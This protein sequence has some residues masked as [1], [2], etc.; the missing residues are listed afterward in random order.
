MRHH[1]RFRSPILSRPLRVCNTLPLRNRN[2]ACP[3]AP[4]TNQKWPQPR[5]RAAVDTTVIG[6]L[7]CPGG[8]M[9]EVG[10]L[11]R[12]WRERGGL[13]QTALARR[14][15]VNPAYV[16][17]LEHGGRGAHNRDLLESAADALGLS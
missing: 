12:G 17:R 14:M 9:D 6:G 10:P 7:Q 11:L 13:S 3:M 16:N 5:C 1:H 2:G 4:I 8:A 15:A